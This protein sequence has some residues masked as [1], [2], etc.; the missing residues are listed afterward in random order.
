MT[1]TRPFED[2]QPLTWPDASNAQAARGTGHDDRL[3]ALAL[4][5]EA[6][7][8]LVGAQGAT[9]RALSDDGG[10]ALIASCGQASALYPAEQSIAA[11][12]GLCATA[13]AR[14]EIASARSLS[15]DA[16]D[17]A[18][19]VVGRSALP[20]MAIPLLHRGRGV[21]VCAM[22]FAAGASFD[23]RQRVLLEGL[24]LLLAAALG[25]VAQTRDE[26]QA[27]L[28]AQRQALS[29]E[30]H[31]SVAQTLSFVKMRMPL[32]QDAIL[33]QDAGTAS[34]YCEDVRKA[35]GSAH[36]NLRQLLTEFRVPVA[37]QGLKDALRSSILMF[38]QRTRVP[39]EFDDRAPDLSL[40]AAQESQVFHIVQEA[41]ANIA[42]HASA[43][44]AW[45]HLA[46]ADGRVEVAIEDD[47][48]GIALDDDFAG[49]HHFGL[50]IMRE[51]AARLGGHLDV[52]PR[53]GG[54][55]RVRL[56]F[57]LAAVATA[58]K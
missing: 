9:L 41:L 57:P 39:L 20:V 34:R 5:L 23:E 2:T 11:D 4:T 21:G 37:P 3:A 32:L 28:L 19:P 58:G 25:D 17:S 31:D 1:F 44:H 7:M 26:L 27:A 29:A 38:S 36:T 42:K 10:L 8:R 13:L 35:V 51:R 55:T 30:V 33:S 54:G 22:Q 43:R 16:G 15:D 53:D 46:Q 24:R 6:V 18:G 40:S 47:G 50:D 12:K 52:G 45:M 49:E 14:G 48:C 56:S